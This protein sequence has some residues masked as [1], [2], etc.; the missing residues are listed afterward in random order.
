MGFRSEKELAIL[1]VVM[2]CFMALQTVFILHVDHRVDVVNQKMGEEQEKIKPEGESKRS[3]EKDSKRTKHRKKLY[4]SDKTN[5][6][7]EIELSDDVQETSD[8]IGYDFEQIC[9]V[10]TAEGGTDKEVCLA[11]AQCLMNAC[12]NHEW[13]YDPTEMMEMYQYATPADWVSDEARDACFEIFLSGNTYA[14]VGNATL[15]YAP[16]YC[17]SEWH[18]QQNYVC[19]ISGVRF[20]EE[21]NDYET[22]G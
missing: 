1:L 16:Q 13:R 4:V 9:A 15:F 3:D 20:F 5:K 18:E 10:V 7:C 8:G 22:S 21:A 19:E 14:P 11:V 2:V 12:E 6:I 17:D